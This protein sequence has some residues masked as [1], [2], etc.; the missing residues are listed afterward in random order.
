MLLADACRYLKCPHLNELVTGDKT[1]CSSYCFYDHETVAIPLNK[2][3]N[4]GKSNCI[5]STKILLIC[6]LEKV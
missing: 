1:Y 3:I 2:I 6:K 4:V 5:H